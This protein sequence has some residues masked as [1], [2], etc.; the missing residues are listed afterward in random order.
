MRLM[1]ALCFLAPT[2]W[3]ATP[4]ELDDCHLAAHL[5]EV[6]SVDDVDAYGWL[7]H[8][9]ALAR[10][11]LRDR[12]VPRAGQLAGDAH[13]SLEMNADRVAASNG[14]EFVDALHE[15]LSEVLVASGRARPDAPKHGVAAR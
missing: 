12:D 3:S 8:D 10:Q 6:G 13:R 2:A 11:A 7:V 4:C 15:A 5:H 1:L 9:L 14:G